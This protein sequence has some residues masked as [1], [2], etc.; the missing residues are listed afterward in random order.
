MLDWVESTGTQYIDTNVSLGGGFKVDCKIQITSLET[1]FETIIGSHEISSPYY[2]NFVRFRKET[3]NYVTWGVGERTSTSFS[4]QINTD[5]TIE[6]STIKTGQYLKING[7]NVITSQSTSVTPSSIVPYIFARYNG[8]GVTFFAKIRL[9]YMKLYNSSNELVR[10]FIPVMDENNVVCLYDKVSENYFYNQGQNELIPSKTTNTYRKVNYLQSSGTQYI[11]TGIKATSNTKVDITLSNFPPD[12]AWQACFGARTS[13]GSSDEY[14]FYRTDGGLYRSDYGGNRVTFPSG[15]NLTN[16]A[17]VI[18]NGA[19]TTIGET[20]I[21]NTASTFTGAYNMYVFALNHAN[22][23][24]HPASYNLY[25]CK[26]YTNGTDLALD[27]IPV[28]RTSDNEPCL[29]DLV[30]GE[31]YTNAGTGTFLYG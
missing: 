27:L 31:F 13:A 8:T 30:N 12:R 21:T 4:T 24:T 1:T 9:Y 17:E 7:T 15:T 11:N 14:V 16:K 5:Y 6:A 28:I 29:Y 18:K 2:N 10:D 20:S 3:N 25:S 26:I 22:S 23:L 19:V